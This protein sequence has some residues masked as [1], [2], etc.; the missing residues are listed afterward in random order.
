MHTLTPQRLQELAKSADALRLSEQ[1]TVRLG[2]IVA[3]VESGLSVS[4]TCDRLGIARSTFHR[5]IERFDPDDLSSLEEASH[6]PIT[7]RESATS[8][9]VIALIRELRMQTPFIGK[10]QI[11]TQL[12]EQHGLDISTSTI[13]RIIERECLYFGNSPLHMRKRMRQNSGTKMH[14]TDT[15]HESFLPAQKNHT[16]TEC[17]CFWCSFWQSHKRNIRTVSLTAIVLGNLALI[18]MYLA[19]THWEGNTETALRANTNQTDTRFFLD[20]STND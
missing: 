6:E 7:K 12:A 17:E 16:P 10:E 15:T 20:S 4:E 1:A 8:S 9:D 13:G 11:C 5:W 18:G 19:T 14:A 3:Y 2:W